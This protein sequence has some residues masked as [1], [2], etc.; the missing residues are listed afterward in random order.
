MVRR[1]WPVHPKRG[2]QLIAAAAAVLAIV[3][4]WALN[5]D[6]LPKLEA[7]NIEIPAAARLSVA[8]GEDWKPA[9]VDPEGYATVAENSR[10]SLRLDPM[11]S[12]IAVL[13][14]QNGYLWRSNPPGGKLAG[15]TVKGTL[16]ENMQSPYILEYTSGTETKRSVTNALDPKMT[17]RYTR[18]GT[19]G[20]QVTYTHT[21]LH[22]SF[23][24]QYRITDSGFEV[25][26]P[27]SGIAETGEA[28]L[29]A[30][31]V[32][33]FFGAVSKAEETGYLFV[34]DGPGGLV[35]YD[36]K[37]P[38]I[39]TVY[40]FPVYGEDPSHL[41]ERERKTPREQI[42]FPVFGLKRGTQAFAAI[43][44]EGQYTA[45]VK[46][47]LPGNISSYNTVS[48]NFSYR[49]E[50]GRKVSGITKDVVGTIQKNRNEDDRRVE[51]RL[52]SG[53][54]A[55]YVGMAQ[56]YRAYLKEGGA[57]AAGLKP[58]DQVPMQLS[59]IG[60]A[61]KPRFGGS[62]YETATT[63]AQA[64]SMVDELMR[65]GAGNIR[66]TYQGWQHSGYARSD[67]RFPVVPEIGG[68]EGA[69]RFIQAMHEKGIQ[70]L[71][72]DYMSWKHPDYSRFQVKSDG[73]R[74][75]DTAVLQ[76]REG[77]FIVDP[78]K[79][80]RGQKDVV[81]RLKGLGVDG[82]HYVEGPGDQV[83]SDFNPSSPLARK[84][85]SYY[86]R[87]LLDYVRHRLGTVGVVRGN[88]YSLGHV[89]F[90]EE[91]PFSSSYDL[92]I[93]ETVPF[94]P[95]ALHGSVEYTSAAGNLRDVYDEQLLKAIEYGAVPYFRLTYSESRVLKDTD[96]SHI[97]SGE[98]AVWKDRIIEEYR[99]F[100]QLAA[101]YHQPMTGH[102]RVSEGVYRTTYADGTSVT[103]NYNT[104]RFDVAKG[105]GA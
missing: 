76:D 51:Y 93:D 72:E 31:N 69:K 19:D 70:V 98:Y 7:M 40:E 71:F 96:Y 33:P 92:M 59:F 32:L 49:Q 87:E 12:Q 4:L 52:L 44:Q 64:E 80:V 24:L 20:I 58:V 60:G 5:R 3:L 45:S 53:D 82:I 22:I 14:K 100:N 25:S 30:L 104:K 47:V 8:Q 97:Y 42:G 10:F 50:Y 6:T 65:L 23:V 95:M 66:V 75:I 105:G 63:F 9:A 39:G 54:A 27:S 16:L 88:D 89:S 73:I 86:Y 67:Q 36:R 2:I 13:N 18:I 15:E 62:R 99:K 85:T 84:D 17:T 1:L 102:E 21:E 68:T 34:P 83:F 46:A 48:A 79:A 55:S 91:L 29:F 94:Y 74:G 35:Y 61:T 101:V 78:V 28:R 11:T 103:V 57:L 26:V 41:K 90:I 77:R 43:V 81:D 37:R 38:A 56:A